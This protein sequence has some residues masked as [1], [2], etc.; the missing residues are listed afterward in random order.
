MEMDSDSVSQVDMEMD[1][2]VT[3]STGEVEISNEDSFD[4]DRSSPFFMASSI[5][6]GTK[7]FYL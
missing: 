4:G 1:T 6:S 3:S 7:T 2:R 5:N